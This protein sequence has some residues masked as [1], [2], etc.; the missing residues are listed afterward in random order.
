MKPLNRAFTLI[1][2][3]VVISII[4][5]L[6]S[7]LLVAVQAL[8]ESSRRM[9]CSNNLKQ[10]GLA[11]EAYHGTHG[12]YPV[13]GMPFRDLLVHLEEPAV[14]AT[15][16]QT[17]LCP[18]DNYASSAL[19]HVSYPFCDGF[20]GQV[21]GANGVMPGVYEKKVV[22]SRDITDG[23]SNT[24]GMSEKLVSVR[25]SSNDEAKKFPLRSY[26]FVGPGYDAPTLVAVEQFMQ[27]CPQARSFALPH[28]TWGSETALALDAGYNH[29]LG[30]NQAP[31]RHGDPGAALKPHESIVPPSSNHS[32]GVNLLML[33]GS[34]H[35]VVSEVSLQ[36]WH[37]WGTR[38][39]G[40]SVA[41]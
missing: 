25:P 27:A 12:H 18:S 19:G 16:P 28:S 30:P 9:S 38:S 40:E 4:G 1:E 23:L 26:W 29:T 41:Q 3:L 39:G 2:L 35:F 6:S 13:R 17:Y 32:D 21:Y 20:A 10:L 11:V 37:A 22:R 31:C 34:V 15:S 36:V 24:A 8:R 33:D 7:L 14:R 5:V